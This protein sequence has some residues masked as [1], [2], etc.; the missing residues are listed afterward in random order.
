MKNNNKQNRGYIFGIVI[1]PEFLE[2]P[3][4]IAPVWNELSDEKIIEHLEILKCPLKFDVSQLFN[5]LTFPTLK[6]NETLDWRFQIEFGDENEVPHYQS[7]IQLKSMSHVS[8]VR[9]IIN[10]SFNTFNSVQGIDKYCQK[11]TKYLNEN[12]SGRMFKH[13]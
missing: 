5:S 3:N 12:Y 10:E 13:S 4:Y 8:D 11:P 6:K 1:Q 7:Y 2:D 9:K